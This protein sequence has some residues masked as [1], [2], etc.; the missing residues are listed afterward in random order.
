[1][2]TKGWKILIL[3]MFVSLCACGFLSMPNEITT[4]AQGVNQ[5]CFYLIGGEGEPYMANTPIGSVDG[6]GK[7]V[8]GQPEK[9]LNAFA[10]DN[11]QFVGWQIIYD[12]QS[13]KTQYESILGVGSPK[14][15]TLTAEDGRTIDAQISSTYVNGYIKSSSFSLDNVFEDLTIR[16]IFDHIYYQVEINE[17]IGFSNITKSAKQIEGNDFYYSSTDDVTLSN[18]T[19][20]IVYEDAII[21]IESKYYFYGEL[22]EIAGNFFSRQTRTND[23]NTEEFIKFNR[24]AFRI[25]ATVEIGYD[26]DIQSDIKN[27]KNIDLKGISIKSNSV[28]KLNVR[29]SET[30]TNCFSISKDSFDRTSSYE[31]EFTIKANSNYKNTVDVDFHNLYVVDLKVLVDGEDEHEELDEVLG[32]ITVSANQMTSNISLYNFYSITSADNMQF[33]VK[34]AQDNNAQSFAINCSQNINKVVEG[35]T[36]TYY[37][38]ATMNGATNRNQTLSNISANVEIVVDYASV[39]YEVSFQSV[40]YTVGDNSQI[41]LKEMDGNTLSPISKKRNEDVKLNADSVA[42]VEN[43]GYKFVGFARSLNGEVVA[44]ID[45]KINKEKPQNMKIYLCYQ[46]ID[47]TITFANYNQIELDGVNPLKSLKFALTNGAMQVLETINSSNFGTIN[48][49][50]TAKINIGT[51]V[52]ITPEINN[53]FSIIGFSLKSPSQTLTATDYFENNTFELSADFIKTN[54]LTENITIYVY[55]DFVSYNLTYYIEKTYDSKTFED[56]IMANISVQAPASASIVR[57]ELNAGGEYVEVEASNTTSII[58]KIVVGSLKLDEVVTLNSEGLNA[59]VAPDT[60]TYVFNF[61]TEKDS[62]LVLSYSNVGNVYSHE[63]TISKSREIKVVYSMPNSKVLITIDEDFASSDNF[64]YKYTI[65]Q[66]GQVLQADKNVSNSYVV[67]VGVKA[68]IEITEI[69]YGYKF[70]GYQLFGTSEVVRLDENKFEYTAS[71]SGIKTLILKFS[72]NSYHFYFKQNG[73]GKV[74]EFVKFGNLDY[75]VLNIDKLTVQFEKPVL[76]YYVASVTFKNG[77]DGYSSALSENNNFRFNE[78]ISTYTFSLTKD[79]IE[80]LVANYD[81]NPDEV[82]VDIYVNITYLIFRYELQVG[83]DLTNPKGDNRDNNVVYPSIS[84]DFE[85]DGESYSIKKPFESTVFEFNEIPY[86]VQATINVLG[87]APY[88][89]SVAGWRYANNDVV[90]SKDYE[91]SSNFLKINS[92]V[93]DKSFV[94]AL[95]YNSYNVKVEFNGSQGEPKVYINNEETPI[96]SIQISLYDK[97][98]IETNAKRNAG[99][100][101]KAVKYYR[102]TYTEYVYDEQTWNEKFESLYLLENSVFVLNTSSIYDSSKTY[103]TYEAEEQNYND[104]VNFVDESFEVSDYALKEKQI[105]FVVEYE[106]LKLSI[107]NEV[108][109]TG[110]SA[111]WKM[112]GRGSNEARIEFELNDLVIIEVVA[113]NNGVERNIGVDDSVTFDDVVKI[114]IKINKSAVNKVDNK[115]YNLSLGLVLYSVYIDGT[116]IGKE[117]LGNG[118]Y[119]IQ[120]AVRNFMPTENIINILYIVE[121]ESKNVYVTTIV[122]DTTS[123][124]DNIKFLINAK[125]Y[126]FES[127]IVE[128]RVVGESSLEYGLQFMAKAKVYSVFRSDSF[129]DDFKVSGVK[130]YCDG[131]EIDELQYKDYGIESVEDWNVIARLMYNLKI[132][133]KIQPILTYKEYPNFTKTFACDSYGNG[134]SQALTVGIDAN[135]DIQHSKLLNGLISIKYVSTEPNSV[136][137]DSVTNCGS[138]NVRIYFNNNED[139]DWLNEISITESITLQIV[140]KGIYLTYNLDNIKPVEKVYDAQTDMSANSIYSYLTFEDIGTLKIDYNSV[141]NVIGHELILKNTK[142]YI[143]EDGKDARNPNANS[144]EDPWYNLYVYD[145]V[146]NN[147][148]GNF[149]LL[150]RD[151]I[152]YD[153]VKITKRSLTLTGVNI[154]NK[155]YDGTAHAELVSYE[156]IGFINKIENDVVVIDAEKLEIKFTD[157]N[158]GTNKK[159]SIIAPEGSLG[160]SGA[161]NYYLNDVEIDGLTIYPYS[162]TAQVN[163]FGNVS[164]INNRGLTDKDKVDLIPLNATF[165][166]E[167]IYINSPRYTSIYGSISQYVKGNNEYIVGYTI[168][169]IVGGEKIEIDKNLHLS[170]PYAKNL[171]GVYFLTGAQ[172]GKVDYDVE[173]GKVIID[174]SQINVDIDS[175]FL[176]QRKVLFKPWQIVLIVIAGVLVVAVVVLVFIIIRKRKTKEYKVHDKI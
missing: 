37:T 72:R 143:S 27:S 71:S 51:S 167:P 138:Y 3:F 59:G 39:E 147:A 149:E 89:L 60:Y 64:D 115:E 110:E 88:G 94:Y 19:S 127:S 137:V 49:T 120:F 136:E 148:D 174:L 140:K 7:F 116:E 83:F 21:K 76:G 141:R 54:V 135:C 26:V 22:Y 87:G 9:V 30:S 161:K 34:N 63:E 151:L 98:V 42:S 79:Q 158:V 6:T 109:E 125:D 31:F 96:S 74:D 4:Y 92:F 124:Y 44:S 8:V 169:L 43:V 142:A 113:I 166:V 67:E 156:T 40:E 112:T 107:N 47:Y 157:V 118:E 29:T 90:L 150:N 153:Y 52:Q 165:S 104:S 102:P 70:V 18:G 152:V 66:N 5:D 65:K 32:D 33:L 84:L 108:E 16:P 36:Y 68:E 129:K 58:A 162:L 75:T 164:L 154:Y 175:F 85:F 145:F 159:V 28:D 41:I 10:K 171:N 132:V 56:V 93:E 12:E 48:T 91:N 117:N 100:M 69:A 155:V 45:D 144:I 114:T 160:G 57:Y 111:R 35:N 139:L 172:A 78:N 122:S 134:I 95:T 126:G 128:N 133:F 103:Y 24:G 170:L 146:L 13:G 80:N 1:M 23:E 105:V 62:N 176:T 14:N 15:I 82:A 77:F 99:Y 17:L 20:A 101:F 2:K 86:G 106:L 38:F 53:G 163:G 121:I 55:E 61:F 123:F 130:I 168:A 46:K 131:V 25:G 73:A 50:L 11:F 97:L 119:S 81:E 173:T